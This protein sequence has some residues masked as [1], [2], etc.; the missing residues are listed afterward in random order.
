MVRSS[1][2]GRSAQSTSC[3]VSSLPAVRASSRCFRRGS[4][5]TCA[6]CA[7]ERSITMVVLRERGNRIRA[8]GAADRPSI[9]WSAEPSSSC[10]SSGRVPPVSEGLQRP[11][12]S[13]RYRYRAGTTRAPFRLISANPQR[14]NEYRPGSCRPKVS[15]RM[16]DFAIRVITS[17]SACRPRPTIFRTEVCSDSVCY[18]SDPRL[19]P[20]PQAHLPLTADCRVREPPRVGVEVIP[21]LGCGERSA[22]AGLP[23]AKQ[24]SW[25]TARSPPEIKVETRRT[26]AR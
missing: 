6:R 21:V 14:N 13:P 10:N 24:F 9:R 7:A 19:N 3:R 8:M 20:T 15:L 2:S 4:S 12:G 16:M 5:E 25:P 23:A 17:K 1:A 26:A 18:P 22:D 11:S